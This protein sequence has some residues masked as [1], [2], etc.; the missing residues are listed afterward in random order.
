MFFAMQ[1]DEVRPGEFYDSA[2]TRWTPLNIWLLQ[3]GSSRSK[4][5]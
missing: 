5:T 4:T 1:P 3:C 2:C